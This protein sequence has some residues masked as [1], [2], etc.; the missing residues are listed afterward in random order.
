MRIVPIAS[1]STS[2][3]RAPMGLDSSGSQLVL[4]HDVP[5]STATKCLHR[6][7]R[8]LLTSRRR[9]RSRRCPFRHE[10]RSLEGRPAW[11]SARPPRLRRGMM[12]AGA[13]RSLARSPRPRRLIRGSC[14]SARGSAPRFLHAVVTFGALR[15]APVAT[16]C[17]RVDS[18]L[19]HADHVQHTKT[20]CPRC[21]TTRSHARLIRCPLR[22]GQW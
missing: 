20:P 11:F 10:T 8:P 7:L 9:R 6:V 22:A 17:F 18:H 3:E 14:P 1:R 13:S 19:L 4:H 2:D 16:P 12:G 15:F 5:A 21:A